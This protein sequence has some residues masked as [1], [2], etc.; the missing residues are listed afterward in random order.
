MEEKKEQVMENNGQQ[1]MVFKDG[2]WIKSRTMEE[3]EERVVG[4]TLVQRE[5]LLKKCTLK[6]VVLDTACEAVWKFV[7]DDVGSLMLVIK[8]LS[9]KIITS[10]D[11]DLVFGC[12]VN[13][14]KYGTTTTLSDTIDQM[15]TWGVADKDNRPDTTGA[16]ATMVASFGRPT[17]GGAVPE[18]ISKSPAVTTYFPGDNVIGSYIRSADG[19]SSSPCTTYDMLVNAITGMVSPGQMG[20]EQVI[21]D[22]VAAQPRALKIK[23]RKGVRKA[24]SGERMMIVKAQPTR[25][26]G[27]KRPFCD[28]VEGIQTMV[29][30]IG[31]TKYGFGKVSEYHYDGIPSLSSSV[32]QKYEWL[33]DFIYQDADVYLLNS[34]DPNFALALHRVIATIKPE[35][36]P[37]AVI[38]DSS[39][40]NVAR[41]KEVFLYN[42]VGPSAV[43]KSGVIGAASIT[44]MSR[45]GKMNSYYVSFKPSVKGK[46]HKAELVSNSQDARAAAHD[47]ACRWT[48]YMYYGFVG[49]MEEEDKVYSSCRGRTGDV[50]FTN[51]GIHD[52]YA[53]AM[54]TF[55]CV[56]HA[57]LYPWYHSCFRLKKG[58]S[59]FYK[60]VREFKKV[61]DFRAV[62]SEKKL[63]MDFGGEEVES[64][65]A[66]ESF[67]EQVLTKTVAAQPHV[68]A[69]VEQDDDDDLFAAMDENAG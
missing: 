15:F 24:K 27:I 41:I 49:S 64:Y 61:Y 43:K 65:E 44:W 56:K 46:G 26:E 60:G 31:T 12:S 23:G 52:R 57:I 62:I 10:N 53:A 35:G 9:R 55:N 69:D 3:I 47:S 8:K 40:T 25:H 54:I 37:F 11:K 13:D 32:R 51:V 16:I 34:S 5:A 1:R 14:Y 45:F 7:G 18:K 39:H 29:T 19:S 68:E 58:D 4:L 2:A 21:D 33:T 42:D 30:S 59:Y 22:L 36:Q 6:D 66:I 50:I 38:Y 67:S 20:R 63:V 48:K 28:I 17:E